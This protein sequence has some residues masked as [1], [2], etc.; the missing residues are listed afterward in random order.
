MRKI[1]NILTRNNFN[2]KDFYNVV[3]KKDDLIGGLPVLCVGIDLTK[4]C[5]PDFNI[6][7]MN[8]DNM[9]MWTY[10]PREKR[11]IYESRLSEFIH[12]AA[13]K[14]KSSIKY[15]YVNV[16]ADGINSATFQYVVGLLNSKENGVVS[17]LNNG[18]VYV[19]DGDN[20]VY[21]IS[22]REMA[23]IGEDAKAFLRILYSNTKVI[24]NKDFISFEIRNLFVGFEYCFPCLFS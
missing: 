2:D 13:D 16:I 12:Y 15:T 11:N 22:L 19:F 9:T 10:G 21:G 3:D 4:E 18:I 6:I 5:Y 17:Y 8:V 1:A 24:T 7:D 14:F 20:T 23:Y